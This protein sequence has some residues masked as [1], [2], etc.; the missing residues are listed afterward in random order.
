M[1]QTLS[2]GTPLAEKYISTLGFSRVR[3]TPYP[4]KM[5]LCLSGR[6]GE[7]K[8]FFWQSCK[9]ALILNTDCTSTSF[10]ALSEHMV[11]GIRKDG[12]PVLPD[13]S[14]PLLSNGLP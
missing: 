6:S 1:T 8:S 3:M 13:P 5:L 7:G 12:Q 14:A 4:T 2:A 11:P 10:A 9:N